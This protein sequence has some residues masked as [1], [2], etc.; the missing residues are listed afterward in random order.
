[1]SL[2]ALDFG[3]VKIGVAISHGFIAEA[4]TTLSYNEKSPENFVLSLKKIIE[5]QGSKILIVGLPL[6]KDEKPT[7]Q[8]I[9]IE[10]NVKKIAKILDIPLKFTD[11]SFSSSE[12]KSNLGKKYTKENVDAESA[13]IILDQY[14]N[15]HP[16]QS[17]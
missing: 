11:E 2:I 16:N 1:M 6:G 13:K 7:R 15:E 14:I 5:E 9:W 3:T 4:Y 8:G 17:L 12:A 10:K